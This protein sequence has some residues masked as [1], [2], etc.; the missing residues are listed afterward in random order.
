MAGYILVVDDEEN[1]L[2][3]LKRVLEKEGW[4]IKCASTGREGI[5][6]AH[7]YPFRLAVLDMFL[8]DSNGIGILKALKTMDPTIS[9]IMITAFPS[10]QKE[11]EA[12]ALGCSAFLF[13]PLDITRLKALIRSEIETLNN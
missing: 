12:K 6:L 11:E 4:Q 3:L 2:A 5:N 13:K 9:V 10:W 1:M 7:Q 8:P